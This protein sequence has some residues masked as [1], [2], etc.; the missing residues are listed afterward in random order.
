MLV[1][2][3]SGEELPTPTLVGRIMG[4]VVEDAEGGP[5]SL[6]RGL[7]K[8][9]N[10]Q[11]ELRFY[12]LLHVYLWSSLARGPMNMANQDDSLDINPRGRIR[13][14]GPEFGDIE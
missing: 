11:E 7:L 3:L 8:E 10:P 6:L 4:T 1:D 14:V 2:A 5:F 13:A 9:H 12:E